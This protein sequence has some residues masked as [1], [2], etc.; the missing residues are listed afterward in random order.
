MKVT[1]II[2]T[3]GNWQGMAE[4][5]PTW[6]PLPANWSAVIYDGKDSELDGTREWLRAFTVANGVDLLASGK[7]LPV[8]AKWDL[9]VPTIKTEWVLLLDSD[10]KLLDRG[11]FASVNALLNSGASLI[12]H[13]LFY[14]AGE[15]YIEAQLPDSRK[16]LMMFPRCE[17][18]FCLVRPDYIRRH[19]LS[20]D[21][22]YFTARHFP[23]VWQSAT[24]LPGIMRGL[25]EIAIAGDAGWQIYWR[26]MR[27][28]A[29]LELPEN[30]RRGFQHLGQGSVRWM[31]KNKVRQEL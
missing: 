8:H 12:G 2:P 4:C 10:V 7:N 27:D 19:K 14:P 18:F 3:L 25:N 1:V 11:I 22:V 6:F 5:L 23:G 9:L 21:M 26:A 13:S 24:E 17:T 28:G 16:P 29:F 31:E 20:F 15:T 30:I